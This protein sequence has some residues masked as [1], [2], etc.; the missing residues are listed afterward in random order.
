MVVDT[1]NPASDLSALVTSDEKPHIGNLRS[2]LSHESD[3]LSQISSRE[4]VETS[5]VARFGYGFELYKQSLAKAEANRKDV[6]DQST[7][8]TETD[9]I[10]FISLTKSQVSFDETKNQTFGV[11]SREERTKKSCKDEPNKMNEQTDEAEREQPEPNVGEEQE[12]LKSFS[13]D[14]TTTKNAGASPDAGLEMPVETTKDGKQTESEKEDG[15]LPEPPLALNKSIDGS[16]Q[17]DKTESAQPH[18]IIEGDEEAKQKKVPQKQKDT[19]LKGKEDMNVNEAS[20]VTPASKA[21]ISSKTV[22]E[23]VVE[24]MRS[25]CTSLGSKTERQ[26]NIVLKQS[27]DNAEEDNGFGA[28]QQSYSDEGDEEGTEVSVDGVLSYTGSFGGKMTIVDEKTRELVMQ[29]RRLQR[30]KKAAD[31]ARKRKEEEER[32]QKEEFEKQMKETMEIKQREAAE[33]RELAQRDSIE[34]DLVSRDLFSLDSVADSFF[35]NSVQEVYNNV[36]V[37]LQAARDT[38][39]REMSE[40]EKSSSSN[41]VNVDDAASKT[42]T[43]L[44]KKATQNLDSGDG[45]KELAEKKPKGE[46]KKWKKIFK[47]LR[48]FLR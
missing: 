23:E 1:S 19:F 30:R 29:A 31:K 41:D 21:P 45:K 14:T 44:N 20:F 48:S 13:S 4:D 3:S 34:D 35:D 24:D 40:I 12:D 42:N 43:T 2:L 37:D 16:I 32:R 17:E 38:A 26:S 10:A 27:K 46:P 47:G 28:L 7:P 39:S 5:T 15:L 11:P 33:M 6:R 25:E 18:H 8:D 9:G 22:K 36:A